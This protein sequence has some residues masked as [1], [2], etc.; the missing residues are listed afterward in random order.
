MFTEWYTGNYKKIAR[1]KLGDMNK[2]KDKRLEVIMEEFPSLF[3]CVKSLYKV[4]RDVL[5]PY[6]NGLFTGTP[7]DIEVLYGLIIKVFN[8]T[9]NDIVVRDL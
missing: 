8:N 5:F 9:I 4:I 3:D 1:I 2:N 7:K 6:R